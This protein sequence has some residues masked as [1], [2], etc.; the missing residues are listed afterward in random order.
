MNSQNVEKY[1]NKYHCNY[2]PYYSYY[3]LYFSNSEKKF[4]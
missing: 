3:K 1:D 2:C 4:I